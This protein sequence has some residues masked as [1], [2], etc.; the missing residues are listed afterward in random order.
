[1]LTKDISTDINELET[2]I[3]LLRKEFQQKVRV[4]EKKVTTLRKQL[5][6]SNPKET[7]VT[8]GCKVRVLSGT[9]KGVEGKVTRVTEQSAWVQRGKEKP[10]LKR[11]YNLL[12]L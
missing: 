10:F 4:I 7:S 8:K 3:E 9:H 1:M 11:K 5:P 2:E 12:I 6:K